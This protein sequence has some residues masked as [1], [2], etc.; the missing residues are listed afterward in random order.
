M[1]L[2]KSILF[3]I[4]AIDRK[5]KIKLFFFLILTLFSSMAE[6]LSLGLLIP[7]LSFFFEDS[8]EISIDIISSFL[9][10]INS[11]FSDSNE[12]NLA[13]VSLLLIF[14]FLLASVIRILTIYFSIKISNS[15][16][17][18]FG[19]KLFRNTLNRDF[20][21]FKKNNSNDLLSLLTNKLG[22]VNNVIFFEFLINFI[23]NCRFIYNFKYNNFRTILNYYN[24][25]FYSCWLF[26]CDYIFKKYFKINSISIFCK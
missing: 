2:K 16:S 14:F 4:T 1:N 18:N 23:F 6:I 5:N 24:L 21:Y 8:K 25:F 20:S 19:E 7:F 12:P 26:N 15:I 22:S 10:K 17:V 9:F 11:F 13:V 3:L